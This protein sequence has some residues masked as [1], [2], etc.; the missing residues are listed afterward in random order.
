MD[1]E[2]KY[3]IRTRLGE[4][5]D[6]ALLSV[7]IRTA[8]NKCAD[9]EYGLIGR[10]EDLDLTKYDGVVEEAVLQEIT[11]RGGEG[12]SQ[13]SENGI[14]RTWKYAEMDGYIHSHIT[15]YARAR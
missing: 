6:D 13:H 11:R 10:P 15:P 1:T 2:L 4:D 7:L 3:S 14:L 12:E 9:W 5:M 8:R